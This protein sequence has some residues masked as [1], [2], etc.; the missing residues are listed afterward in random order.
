MNRFF[1][2]L[3]SQQIHIPTQRKEQ[4]HIVDAAELL[5]EWKDDKCRY[6]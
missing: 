6:R 2:N 4:P 3:L 5:Q 1:W